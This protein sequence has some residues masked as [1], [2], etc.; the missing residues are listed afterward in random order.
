MRN[1]NPHII[2]GA[3][4]CDRYVLR[5]V[6]DPDFTGLSCF[7]SSFSSIHPRKLSLKCPHKGTFGSCLIP[8][9]HKHTVEITE[10][11]E[12][13]VYHTCFF[14]ILIRSCLQDLVLSY[15]AYNQT[16]VNFKNSQWYY[17]F[18]KLRAIISSN[19]WNNIFH[20]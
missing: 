1:Y 20:K 3:E 2:F 17:E 5:S 15:Y 6:I 16:C 9:E 8:K 14:K 11:R 7:F 19:L 10:E 4:T 13:S 12:E 18:L